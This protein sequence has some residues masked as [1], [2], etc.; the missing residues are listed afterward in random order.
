MKKLAIVIINWNSY[1]VTNTTL[2]SLKNTS[3]IDYDIILV[4]NHSTDGSIERLE[5]DFKNIIILKADQ[6]LGFTGGNNIG[7]DYSIEKGYL[8]TMLLNNDV[9]VES[10]FL[11][12]LIEVL[13]LNEG[14]G[15]VQPLIYFHHDRSI[16]WNAGCKFNPW[17]GITVTKGYNKRDIGQK[18]RFI[19]KKVD[20]ITGCAFMV[21]TKLFEQVGA[22]NNK[23]FIYYEDVDLS[24]RIK[25]V[26]FTLAYVP[27]SVIY[28]IAGVSHK[29]KEKT[30]EGYISSKVHYLNSR[31]RIWVLKKYIKTYAI[32][33]VVLYHIF[34][35]VAVGCYFILRRR[36]NK[37]NAWING[38]KDGLLN[39]L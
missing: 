11:E 37:L 32:P 28:H 29:S 12:P 18:E 5:N 3:F 22:L 17:L 38:I 10:N 20:W 35:F 14:V 30:K 2:L 36:W 1:D 16:I 39:S 9:E 21:R 27:K 8:Y 15:A 34:Y 24:F 33:T 4:D 7:I 26:G 23:F 31:N 13:D 19:E 25:Q 6:N